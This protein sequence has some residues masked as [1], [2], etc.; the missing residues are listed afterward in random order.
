MFLGIERMAQS[1]R[2]DVSSEVI[3]RAIYFTKYASMI[4]SVLQ[5]IYIALLVVTY[6]KNTIF[7]SPIIWSTSSITYC[8]TFIR[9][10]GFVV[11]SVKAICVRKKNANAELIQIISNTPETPRTPGFPVPACNLSSNISTADTN[12]SNMATIELPTLDS[13]TTKKDGIESK[14]VNSSARSS[15]VRHICHKSAS[16]D[17]MLHTQRKSAV[18][19]LCPVRNSDPT[20]TITPFRNSLNVNNRFELELSQS[21]S[22]SDDDEITDVAGMKINQRSCP[23]LRSGEVTKAKSPKMAVHQSYEDMKSNT[24]NFVLSVPKKSEKLEIIIGDK[25]DPPSKR[26]SIYEEIDIGDDFIFVEDEVADKKKENHLT[27]MQITSVHTMPMTLLKIPR[28]ASDVLLLQKSES[29]PMPPKEESDFM[30]SLLAKQGFYT[31]RNSYKR[32]RRVG[33]DFEDSG[34]VFV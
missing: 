29:A 21:H 7:Y 8:L 23:A 5:S 6:D 12:G 31:P 20:P 27:P 19:Q 22:S 34:L 28:V 17:I 33:N 32:S 25:E 4:C 24:D 9:N 16:D 2:N 3:L 10:R 30:I 18:P 15:S 26:T 11:R 13:T 14:V 1:K